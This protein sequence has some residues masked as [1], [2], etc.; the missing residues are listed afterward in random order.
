MI[1][2]IIFIIF[3]TILCIKSSCCFDKLI[4]IFLFFFFFFVI[5]LFYLLLCYSLLKIWLT[6]NLNL[7]VFELAEIINI[8]LYSLLL[9]SNLHLLELFYT[10]LSS[11]L[12]SCWNFIWN[13]AWYCFSLWCRINSI[14]FVRFKANLLNSIHLKCIITYLNFSLLGLLRLLRNLKGSVILWDMPFNRTFSWNIFW[15]LLLLLINHSLR[16]L[17]WLHYIGLVL[18]NIIMII[19]ITS[20][21]IIIY[22]MWSKFIIVLF[23][24]SRNSWH[25]LRKIIVLLILIK[26]QGITEWLMTLIACLTSNIILFLFFVFIFFLFFILNYMFLLYIILHFISI[27]QCIIYSM[28]SY[29]FFWKL[30]L[31]S[32]LLINWILVMKVSC[33]PHLYLRLLAIF[34]NKSTW[35]S[36]KISLIQSIRTRKL[37]ITFKIIR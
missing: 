6:R 4:F 24:C 23:I 20:D 35:I 10:I 28:K 7:L 36:S 12:T 30:L 8:S 5:T 37:I 22:I 3:S 34:W 32:S 9:I 26:S 2:F 29:L 27:N 13:K 1:I 31:I 25:W 33:K 11:I 15:P 16:A 21:L 17:I 18:L 14:H 19:K